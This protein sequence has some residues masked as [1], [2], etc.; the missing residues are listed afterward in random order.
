[1]DDDEGIIEASEVASLLR[2]E[3]SAVMRLVRSGHLP[4]TRIGSSWLFMRTDIMTF[5][6]NQID[7]E[8]AAR[9]LHATATAK[10]TVTATAVLLP[11][12]AGKRR[13]I[14]PTLPPVPGAPLPN[15]Y[16]K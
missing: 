11:G 15:S 2:T 10:A 8:T 3:T 5:L 16:H 4:S 14:L 9:R 12:T 7:E 6:R 1:M 13:T